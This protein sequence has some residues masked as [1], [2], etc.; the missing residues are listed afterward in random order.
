MQKR[1]R[2][3]NCNALSRRNTIRDDRVSLRHDVTIREFHTIFI[4]STAAEAHNT[5]KTVT[6]LFL[7]FGADFDSKGDE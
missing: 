1:I 3:I 7:T 6:D 5:R 4:F 2:N